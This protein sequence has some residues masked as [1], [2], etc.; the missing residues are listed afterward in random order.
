MTI[1]SSELLVYSRSSLLFSSASVIQTTSKL[2]V[3]YY[4]TM[5]IYM[6]LPLAVLKCSLPTCST[7]FYHDARLRNAAV[8]VYA[9]LYGR[10]TPK[11]VPQGV[12]CQAKPNITKSYHLSVRLGWEIRI[13]DSRLVP[14]PLLGLQ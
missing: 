8:Q 4:C 7:K 14:R 2:L 13:A 11:C 5:T 6:C 1:L 3:V 10:L 12:C 9:S